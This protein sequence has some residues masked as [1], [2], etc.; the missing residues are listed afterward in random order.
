MSSL[1]ELSTLRTKI[2]A[3]I[4]DKNFT[5]FEV[6]TYTNSSI[7]TLAEE[8]INEI[9]KVLKNGSE[10]GSGD[11]TY[12][13]TTNKITITAS[14]S[15]NDTIEV[16]YTY[17]KYSDTEL[18]EYMRASLVWLSVF[19]ENSKDYEIEEIGIYPTPENRTLDLI[20][21]ISS[22][23]IKP[24]W[25]QY[26]MPNVT[27]IY[28]NNMSKETKIERLINRFTFSSGVNDILEFD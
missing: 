14:L 22:I 3:L 20:C 19:D 1:A 8:N 15:S 21:L 26:R 7:F 16:D 9:T 2:R 27:V 4:E 23:L 17:Y 24:D 18:D 13:S 10:L 5:D 12:D 25:T 11:Y 6:F 28:Q